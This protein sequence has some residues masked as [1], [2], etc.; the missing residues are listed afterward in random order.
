MLAG[1]L[2]VA[3]DQRMQTVG[4]DPTGLR[5]ALA[6]WAAPLGRLALEVGPGERPLAVLAQRRVMVAALDGVRLA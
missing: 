6:G 2:G 5:L 1:A 3:R 4:L